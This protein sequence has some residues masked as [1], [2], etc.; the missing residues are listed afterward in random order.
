MVTWLI[1]M[2]Y[3]LAGSLHAQG[4]HHM[5]R[6]DRPKLVV[7]V[8]E[9]STG[10]GIFDPEAEMR[11]LAACLADAYRQDSSN[12][13]LARELRATFLALPPAPE[14]PDALDLLRARYIDRRR[15]E[16]SRY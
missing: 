3:G 15:E 7:S 4:D 14:E 11:L 16:E 10:V 9:I 5:C 1:R 2:L 13:A 6:H 12:A 8:P